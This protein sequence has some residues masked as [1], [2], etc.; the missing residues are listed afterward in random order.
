MRYFGGIIL[1]ALGASY[2][3]TKHHE[4]KQGQIF[5]LN[6]V[7]EKLIESIEKDQII[8]YLNSINTASQQQNSNTENSNTE[9]TNLIGKI[10]ENESTKKLMWS[11][12]EKTQLQEIVTCR[13]IVILSNID[14]Q[15]NGI[16]LDLV[17]K[18]ITSKIKMSEYEKKF[19]AVHVNENT[20]D[21]IGSQLSQTIN[22]NNINY[23]IVNIIK[24]F[25]LNLTKTFLLDK[26]SGELNCPCGGNTK[27]NIKITSIND[28]KTILNRLV[29]L[30]DG[31]CP[32][33]FDYI[34]TCL[35][36]YKKVITIADI[37]LIEDYLKP[38]TKNTNINTEI[39]KYLQL[40]QIELNSNNLVKIEAV[41]S[42][43]N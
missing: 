17:P 25:N 28:G 2:V 7:D 3:L 32:P 4:M 26:Y 13:D 31:N 41:L 5:P 1:L 6:I 16:L 8:Y 35:Q 15:V 42:L 40:N 24:S 37:R 12:L 14:Q 9:E 30:K 11:M 29:E 34:A 43:E 39:E 10:L 22:I 38:G 20:K 33:I 36:N 18:I 27:L 21:F 23:T 19:F